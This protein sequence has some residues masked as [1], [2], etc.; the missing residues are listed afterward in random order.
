M[1]KNSFNSIQY[2]TMALCFLSITKEVQSQAV[3]T[4]INPD[5]V[6]DV[7]GEIGNIDMNNDGV[8]D[9]GFLNAMDTIF[10]LDYEP[11]SYLERI[12]GGPKNPNNA[13]AGSSNQFTLSYGGLTTYYYPFVLPN[14]I[15]VNDSMEFQ[16]AGYQFLAFRTFY[17]TTWFSGTLEGGNW[18]PEILDQYIGVRFLDTLGCNHYGWLRC[19][20]KDE[21]RTL[22]I[23]DYAYE[24]KCDTAILTG[25][26][27]GDTTEI[28]GIQHNNTIYPTI[29]TFDSKVYVQIKDNNKDYSIRIINLSGAIQFTGILENNLTIISLNGKSKGYYLVEI[30]SDNVKCLTKKIYIN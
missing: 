10:T 14:G 11:Q 6:I 16:T 27:I 4:D 17:F 29:Y 2:S 5:M 30:F 21:G 20:V 28:V 7:D 15:L 3:Y 24:T 1:L 18:Y 25:D 12:Y 19:D 23:K 26:T 8:L 13:I 9:F 22:V